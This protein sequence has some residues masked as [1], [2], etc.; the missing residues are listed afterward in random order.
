MSNQ[1]E[2]CKCKEVINDK[3]C[4]CPFKTRNDICIACEEGDHDSGVQA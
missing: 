3:L 4:D 2:D 1:P